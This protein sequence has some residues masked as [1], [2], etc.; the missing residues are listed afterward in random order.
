MLVLVV[1]VVLFLVPNEVQGLVFAAG[2]RFLIVG[3]NLEV[4]I[5]SL[6]IRELLVSPNGRLTLLS[7]NLGRSVSRFRLSRLGCGGDTQ[8]QRGG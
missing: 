8:K 6:G 4:L 3:R 1:G 7:I 5:V 2:V